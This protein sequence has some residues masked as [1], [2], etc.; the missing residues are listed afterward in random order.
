MLDLSSH[1]AIET[2]I[3]VKWEIP[4]VDTAYL[5]D[6]NTPITFGGNLYTNIGNLLSLSGTVGNLR[7]S[8]SQLS[9]ILSGIDQAS[10]PAILSQQ[11][12]GSKIEIYR[13]V[14]NP[15]THALIGTINPNPM[16]KYKGIITGF[17]VSDSVDITSLTATSTIT[18]ICAS[19]V[20]ILMNKTTGRRTNP[21]DFPD[22]ASMN[23]VTALA[24][25]NFNFGAPGEM[26]G[27]VSIVFAG[28]NK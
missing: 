6:Y 24:N 3:F 20:E 26:S 23:R 25:S 1:S 14:F 11:I 15:T 17:E 18:L 9:I 13:G 12:R 22:E 7:A 5:S 10:I 16:L 21:A 2:G 28:A 4:N 19:P 27:N 8:T